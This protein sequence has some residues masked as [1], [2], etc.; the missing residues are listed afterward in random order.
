[1]DDTAASPATPS[2]ALQHRSVTANGIQLHYV[3]A[4]QGEPVLLIPGWPQSWY[5]WRSVIPLLVKAGRQVLAIDPRG[6]GDSEKPACGYDLDTSAE[7]IHAFIVAAGLKSD[8][9][10]DIISHNVGTWIAYAHAVAYPGDVRR[11]VL[12][13]ALVPGVPPPNPPV[14]P[15]KDV[16]NE[17]SWH[18]GFNRLNDLPETL[19]QGHER[20]Y[21]SWLFSSKS[22]RKWVFTPAVLDEYVRIFASP[23]AA[24]A[25]FEYYRANFA[26]AALTS[27][28]ARG[29]ARLTM[30][31]LTVGAEGGVGQALHDSIQPR[32]EDVQ[33]VVLAGCGHY[34]AEEDPA[35]FVAAVNAFWS[36][37]Q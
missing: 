30:P 6:F 36:S 24:R 10:L 26:D 14:G 21:L 29:A 28:Q 11:L 34:V 19:V 17:R 3:I 16:A 27:R 5:A 9:G 18:F 7:D 31:V 33:G 20:A 1:M 23:G 32:G 2:D 22:V 4:G 12:S 37:R 25:G 13:D 35:Q 8:G 15:P